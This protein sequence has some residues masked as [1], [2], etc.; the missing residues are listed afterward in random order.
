MAIRDIIVRYGMKKAPED[1]I[2]ESKDPS[3]SLKK[4]LGA[5]DLVI[6]GVGGI[7]G[8]GIFV[9][10][11]LGAQQAGPNIVWAF[12][13]AGFICALAGL[14][15]AELASTIPT[16]GSAYAYAYS[17][18]GETIAWVLGWALV[19]EYAVGSA[20]VAIGWSGNF[21]ALTES[22]TG[23]DIPLWATASHEVFSD[24]PGGLVNIPA[25]V[26]VALIT[27]LLVVGTKTMARFASVFVIAKVAILAMVIGIGFFFVSGANFA[28]PSPPPNP[29]EWFAILGGVGPIVGAAA[30]IFFAYIGF[31]AV[32]TTAEET[33]NPKRDL[34]IGILGSLFI[35]TA[36]YILASAVLV[37]MVPYTDFVPDCSLNDGEDPCM[38]GT[39]VA[40][41]DAAARLNEP[42]GHAFEAGGLLWAANLIRAG[43]ILGITSVLMVLLMGGPRVF[44][45]L[46]RDGLLPA[47]WS[48]VHG[49]FGTPYRTTIG[50]GIGVAL[51]A[52][53]G[54]LGIAGQLTNIGTAFAFAL[55]CLAV[56]VLRYKK[57]DLVRPF[58]VPW[59]IGKFPILAA[60][61]ALLCFGLMM[62][63]G[64]ATI[65]AFL[66]WMG[67]GLMFYALYGIRKS[68]LFGHVGRGPAPAKPG[69]GEVVLEEAR[70]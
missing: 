51:F 1:V 22:L 4:S 11:G 65:I 32:S 60:L 57:P 49:K 69:E 54:T 13:L 9:L 52:G 3:R 15:Y 28:L 58:R 26:I 17:S 12:V 70:G 2:A 55:V 14:A 24:I 31:D 45:A 16:S 46:A 23:W 48:K 29:N 35:C 10:V 7:I 20:A 18:L 37:G 50:T 33:K 21:V 66:G 44:F 27:T 6:L 8:A 67:I 42:F 61:G 53:F 34:P 41:A 64:T 47:S 63:T 25:I 59:N 5:L 30:V 36:L 40:P 19:L 43:A 39:G 56:V 38:A 62:S 68:K